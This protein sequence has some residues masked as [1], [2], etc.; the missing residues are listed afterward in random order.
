[1][2]FRD[3]IKKLGEQFIS[4]KDKVTTEE[5][6]KTAFILPFIRILGYDDADPSEVVPEFTADIGMK[7]GEKVDYAIFSNEKPIIIIEC[8]HHKEKL[9]VH[10]TQLERYFHVTEAKFAIITNGQTYRFYTDLVAL[11][12]MDEKPFLE[13]DITDFKEVEVNELSKFQ[14]DKFNSEE[15]LAEITANKIN[16]D[17]TN[18]LTEIIKNELNQPSDSFVNFFI[19]KLSIGV[20]DAKVIEKFSPILKEILQNVI[21]KMPVLSIENE[22]L[23]DSQVLLKE[24]MA[25]RIKN[26][27]KT[28]NTLR[29]SMKYFEDDNNIENIQES[30]KNLE[31]RTQDL[32]TIIK[33]VDGEDKA[34]HLEQTQQ[35]DDVETD[36]SKG[37]KML[38]K[39]TFPDKTVICERNAT[40]T[41]IKTFQII[42]LD[43]I[44]NLGIVMNGIPLIHNKKDEKYQQRQI[45]SDVFLMTSMNT[46]NKV[47]YLKLASDTFNLGLIIEKI[48]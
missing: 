16:L 1:M 38:I 48:G 40:E 35:V 44:K 8:K 36:T 9:D 2:D 33:P 37:I 12:K 14:K 18:H 47:K 6:T 41:Y 3:K 17:Y 30:I 28:A 5:G 7:K 31:R 25:E 24:S 29:M 45:S 26:M 46:D 34:K 15:I 39:V 42:G 21:N 11:N 43:K 19:S 32:R 13:I 20:V 22:I 4:R 23:E 27:E 10:K